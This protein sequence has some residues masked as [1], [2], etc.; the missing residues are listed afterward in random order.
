MCD[1][2]RI[3][4]Q[5]YEAAIIPDLWK[6]VLDSLGKIAIGAGTILAIRRADGWGDWMASDEL[7][8]AMSQF[9]QSDISL[10]TEVT[11]RLVAAN[12]AGFVSELDVFTRDQVATDPFFAELMNPRGMGSVLATAIQIPTGDLVI[13]QIFRRTSQECFDS[14]MAARLDAL[15]PHLARSAMLS[16]RLRLQ[17][18]IAAAEALAM[19]GLPAGILSARGRVLA[20]NRLLEEM[21]E[22]VRCGL[23]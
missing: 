13:F 12:H 6:P 8:D 21:T 1:T 14:K 16:A 5:I 2:E 7:A 18:L 3:I 11:T 17:R 23:R 10:R 9:I 4:D 15:R 22:H 19:I 20:A